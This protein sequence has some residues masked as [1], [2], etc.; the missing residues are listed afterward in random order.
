KFILEDLRKHADNFIH[1][2]KEYRGDKLKDDGLIFKGKTY[3]PEEAVAVGLA[4]KMM[5]LEELINNL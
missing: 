4:D 1:S 3:S 5:T 2:M